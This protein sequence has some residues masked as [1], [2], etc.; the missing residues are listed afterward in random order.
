[1]VSYDLRKKGKKK[2]GKKKGPAPGSWL[3][4]RVG[5]AKGKKR[6]REGEREWGLVRIQK[7]KKGGKMEGPQLTFSLPALVHGLPVQKKKRGEALMRQSLAGKEKKKGKKGG[8]KRVYRFACFEAEKKGG[9]CLS[10][11]RKLGKKGK[12]KEN[13][14]LLNLHLPQKGKE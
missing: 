13:G 6:R 11:L 2:G 9:K 4:G 10:L 12:R 7:K 8:V 3:K 14:N 1:M 5:S